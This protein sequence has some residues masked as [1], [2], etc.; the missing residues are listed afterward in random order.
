MK[1]GEKTDGIYIIIA[2]IVRVSYKIFSHLFGH[3]S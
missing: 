2:G 3:I 1:R